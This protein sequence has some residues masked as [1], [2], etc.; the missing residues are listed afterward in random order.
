MNSR[1]IRDVSSHH[2]TH[3]RQPKYSHSKVHGLVACGGDDGAVE[4]FDMKVRSSVGRINVVA[5]ACDIDQEV[6]AIEFDGEG[7]YFMAVGS[8]AGK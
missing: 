7:G 3:S 2:L 8:S 4:C 5:P 1:I 6:T